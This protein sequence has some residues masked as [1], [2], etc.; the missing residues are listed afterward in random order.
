[1]IATLPM[2]LRPETA[3][4]TEALWALVRDGLRGRGIDAP[5]TLHPD[6][7]M[8][9]GWG[10]PDL[11]LGQICNLPWRARF[12]ETVTLIGAA[13]YALPGAAPGMYHS[14]VIVH[15][16]SPIRTMDAALSAR[17]AANDALSQSGWGAPWLWARDRAIDLTLH[18]ITGSHAGSLHAVASGAA[19]A[20]AIDAQTWR[21]LLRHD[22]AAARVRVVGRTGSSP[23]LT[24][25]TAR[26]NDP[27]PIRA[28]LADAISALPARHRAAMDLCG[29]V[30]HPAS[31]YDLPIPP[32]AGA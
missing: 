23:G 20:A 12:R 26:G 6:I 21:L 16:D 31:A 30:D 8:T 3:P 13:D 4:A 1:M 5:E 9:E 17:F 29:I 2:Y 24:F 18:G 11:V 15:R 25:C 7:G 19:D 22:T 27:D 10:H 28:A 14:V 32:S